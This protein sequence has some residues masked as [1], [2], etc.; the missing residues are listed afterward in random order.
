MVKKTEVS[1][2]LKLNKEDGK[3]ILKGFGI[4]M[5]GAAAAFALNL[6]PQIDF[7]SYAYVV[8]PMASVALNAIV[9]ICKGK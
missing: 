9:K 4:A 7:G 1:K 8:V 6:I 5:G 3:K 2:K